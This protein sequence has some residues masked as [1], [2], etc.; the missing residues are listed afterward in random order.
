VDNRDLYSLSLRVDQVMPVAV[1]AGLPVLLLYLMISSFLGGP[2]A[3][4]A[5]LTLVAGAVLILRP[6]TLLYLITFALFSG[7]FWGI[8]LG[9]GFL[10]L[11]IMTALSLL[12]TKLYHLDFDLAFPNQAYWLAGFWIFL[13]IS[14]WTAFIPVH[15]FNYLWVYVKLA[16]FYLLVI[17]I[18]SDMKGLRLVVFVAL[19]A[20]LVSILF[21]F[22]D[23]AHKVASAQLSIDTRLRGLTDDPNILALH[24]VLL[25]PLVIFLAFHHTSWRAR[26]GF[27]AVFLLLVSG[28]VGTFSRGGFL[29]FTFVVVVALYRRRSWKVLAVTGIILA[30]VAVFF[31]PKDFWLHLGKLWNLG[32]FLQDRS[33]RERSMLLV[34]AWQLFKQHFLFGIGIGNFVLVSQRFVV[35]PLA[36]HNI[37]L[38]VAVETGVFG[39]ICFVGLIASTY[40][41]FAE[42]FE[43]L[44]SSGKNLDAVVMEGLLVGFSGVLVASLFLSTQEYFVV[45]FLF[46]I[47]VVAKWAATS[48]TQEV[49]SEEIA[50]RSIP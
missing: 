26:L 42:A 50:M 37:F 32:E 33:L 31:V 40:K 45:W 7:I 27:F 11:T 19:A 34:G 2:L 43:S 30:G 10:A 21:G 35:E 15:S 44:R 49:L 16:I 4:V 12:L 6:L 20:T 39:L 23:L 24:I 38:Q 1:L 46:A 9:G 36:V 17:N 14:V 18:L 48:Q 22:Y 41:N 28:L 47:S 25:S 8:G 29:A 3:L 5:I 13:L